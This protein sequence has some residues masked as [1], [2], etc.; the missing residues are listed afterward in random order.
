M[1]TQKLN[2]IAVL[3]ETVY[4]PAW[5]NQS[6]ALLGTRGAP[7]RR[8][9]P[10]GARPSAALVYHRQA[11]PEGSATYCRTPSDNINTL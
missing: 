6:I 5:S 9:L 7:R 10:L 4:V 3:E 11:Q 1:Q 8:D 2:H